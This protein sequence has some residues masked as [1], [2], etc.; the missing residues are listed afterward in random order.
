MSG[1]WMNWLADTVTDYGI[2]SEMERQGVDAET[3]PVM[4]SVI[5]QA[6]ALSDNPE[7]EALSSRIQEHPELG[8]ALSRATG[9]DV[10]ALMTNSASGTDNEAQNLLVTVVAA[11]NERTPEELER[12]NQT[13]THI[14]DDPEFLARLNAIP[15]DEIPVLT[16]IINNAATLSEDQNAQE[17]QAKINS[18]PEL[19]TMFSSLGYD[20]SMLNN[21]DASPIAMLDRVAQMSAEDRSALDNTLGQLANNPQGLALANMIPPQLLNTLGSFVSGIMGMLNPIL[22]MFNNSFENLTGQF[23]QMFGQAM[24]RLNI[25]GALESSGLLV[26][27]GNSNGTLLS[28]FAASQQLGFESERSDYDANGIHTDPNTS[29]PQPDQD[30]QPGA[31]QQTMDM[32]PGG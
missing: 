12:I 3:Q 6:R 32:M 27:A 9:F 29:A 18:D 11:L 13:L 4:A 19:L 23:D 7:F 5:S 16:S 20:M 21:D 14:S 28:D 26:T 24:E 17:L 8:A 22:E 10:S 1:N 30:W 15:D 25:G 2:R 31:I